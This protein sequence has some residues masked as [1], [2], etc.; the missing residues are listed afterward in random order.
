[1]FPLAGLPS[2]FFEDSSAS[3]PRL[4]KLRRCAIICTLFALMPT[5]I[6][7][8]FLL[9]IRVPLNARGTQGTLRYIL[10]RE[11]HATTSSTGSRSL[12]GTRSHTKSAESLLKRRGSE[13][14]RDR[15]PGW[16]PQTFTRTYL[17]GFVISRQH[18]EKQPTKVGASRAGTA[19]VDQFNSAI[20]PLGDMICHP[21]PCHRIILLVDDNC[22]SN[23][24][25]YL[26]GA[27]R[28]VSIQQTI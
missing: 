17:T 20:H 28:I 27:H 4:L 25:H 19:R 15:N 24:L 9:C 8:R 2:N 22:C 12:A 5:T 16:S 11:V 10:R 7:I 18:L 13:F 23:G 14:F 21:K 1:M 26:Q 3:S 6:E